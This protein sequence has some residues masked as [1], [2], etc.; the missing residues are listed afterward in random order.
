[1]RNG[2]RCSWCLLL[3]LAIPGTARG[4]ATGKRGK[5]EVTFPVPAGIDTC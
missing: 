3:M 5:G 2:V 1:M 4:P